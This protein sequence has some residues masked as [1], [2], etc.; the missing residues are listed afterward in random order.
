[1]DFPAPSEVISKHLAAKFRRQLLG[2]E[3]SEK[4]K[5]EKKEKLAARAEWLKQ[6]GRGAYETKRTK[7]LSSIQA[8][9]TAIKSTTEAIHEKVG[10]ICNVLEGGV[11]GRHAYPAEEFCG[12]GSKSQQHG[13]GII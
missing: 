2:G 12:D 11:Q 4:A 13:A 1:M 8:D 10:V 3:L 9:T 5:E 6:N 7:Q